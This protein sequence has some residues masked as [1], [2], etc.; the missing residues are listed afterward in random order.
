MAYTLFRTVPGLLPLS[1]FS[2][3]NFHYALF[4][5][6]EVIESTIGHWKSRS[7]FVSKL[8]QRI[9]R[10]CLNILLSAADYNFKRAI[11]ALWEFI[12]IISWRTFSPIVS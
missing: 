9:G 12:K 1:R 6:R 2:F 3:P 8:L 5:K 10:E 7:S 11:K 4:C